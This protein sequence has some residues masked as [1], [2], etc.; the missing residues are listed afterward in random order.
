MS[1]SGVE[2]KRGMGSDPSGGGG[3]WAA[4]GSS[5]PPPG[6]ST[7]QPPPAP[8]PPGWGQP[9][10]TDPW[11][12]QYGAPAAPRPGIVPLRPLGVGELLDGSFGLIRRYPRATLG[13][14]AGVMLVVT[15]V[16]VLLQW[17]LL[18]GIATP[19]PNEPLS[20]A[21][22]YASRVGTAG[23]ISVVIT[24][25]ATLLLTGLITAVVGEAV[26]GRPVSVADAWKQLRPLFGRLI[27]LSILTFLLWIAGALPGIVLAAVGAGVG[28]VAVAVVGLLLALAGLVYVWALFALAPAALVLEKQT[29][30]RAL[31]RSRALVRRSWWRVFLILTLAVV[32][33][34]VVSGIISLPFGLAGG[35]LTTL[36]DRTSGV[37]FSSLVIS[38]LGSLLAATLVRPFTAGVSALLYIDR[39]IR[40][41]ALDVTLT[42]VAA[43][44]PDDLA[45]TAEPPAG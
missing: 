43:R 7:E 30:R 4:P 21:S 16:Q 41:E 5:T 42:R 39:R 1:P 27:G 13:L 28:S 45:P 2:E 29:A 17:W 34:V 33:G 25:L 14:A 40:A 3:D 31:A 19:A 18:S 10:G 44:T 36:G 8:A 12:H 9:G 38:G 6:W 15:T 23:V 26:L 35:G 20:K 11:G 32:L 24:G 22:D 37:Q